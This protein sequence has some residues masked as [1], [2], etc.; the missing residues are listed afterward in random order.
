MVEIGDFHQGSTTLSKKALEYMVRRA[1]T[2]ETSRI[3]SFSSNAI[4]FLG[5]FFPKSSPSFGQRLIYPLQMS[6]IR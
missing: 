1:E 2:L 5:V 4:Y 6:W 3:F